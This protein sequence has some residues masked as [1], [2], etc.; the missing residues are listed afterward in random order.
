MK[1]SINPIFSVI[2]PLYNKAKYINSA[3]DSVLSQSIQDFEIIVIGGNSTDGSDDIVL[4]Y[5]DSRIK[6]VHESGIGVSS[7]RNQ[8]IGMSR[9]NLIAFLD[10]DDEWFPNYLE[11]ILRMRY[12]YP[13]AGIYSTDYMYSTANPVF[14]KTRCIFHKM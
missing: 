12:R 8:G 13:H 6:F 2:I 4:N 1:E 3:L 7:A 5:S 10:A 14:R 11:T 9:G